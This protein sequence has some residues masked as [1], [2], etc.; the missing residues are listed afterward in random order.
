MLERHDD[1]AVGAAA[2]RSTQD[3]LRA[4]MLDC[5]RLL[6]AD[7]RWRAADEQWLRSSLRNVCAHARRDGVHIECLI[8]MLKHAWSA[9][10]ER[11]CVPRHQSIETL[12]RVVSACIDEYYQVRPGRASD[13]P[14]PRSPQMDQRRAHSPNRETR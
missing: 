1:P 13:R 4:E 5:I 2:P 10:P 14:L 11:G 12:A 3:T 9:L 6:L 8:V 7:G